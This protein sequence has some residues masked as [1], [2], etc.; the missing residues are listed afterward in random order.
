V[1][2]DIHIYDP[3]LFVFVLKAAYYVIGGLFTVPVRFQ[4]F[5]YVLVP[6][7]DPLEWLNKRL[8][9]GYDGVVCCGIAAIFHIPAVGAEALGEDVCSRIAVKSETYLLFL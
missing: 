9:Y 3:V 2:V 5:H 1:N 8:L 4:E 7:G 6:H